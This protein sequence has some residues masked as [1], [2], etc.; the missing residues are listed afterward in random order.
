VE[1]NLAILLV[2]LGM[3][4]LLG[5][6][7]SGLREADNAIGETHAALFADYVL[8]GLEANAAMMTN[9]AVWSN[10]NS[11]RAQIVNGIAMDS[12]AG[13]SMQV[14]PASAVSSPDRFSGSSIRYVLEMGDNPGTRQ[15]RWV[16]LW[17]WSGE[18]ISSDIAVFEGKA[19]HFYAELCFLG[20][21]R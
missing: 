17:V 21:L 11:F 15:S 13:I 1:V 10:T 14:Y 12:G 20:A 19:K 6:F 7:P 2:A 3:L 4:A 9:W 18:H 5:L 16:A 8:S